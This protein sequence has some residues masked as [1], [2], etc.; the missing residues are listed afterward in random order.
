VRKFT[1]N[2]F[3]NEIQSIAAYRFSFDIQLA[4]LQQGKRKKQ[5]PFGF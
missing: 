5:R 2:N 3:E 1:Y 4:K